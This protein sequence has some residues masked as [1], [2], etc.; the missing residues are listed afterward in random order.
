M[1]PQD[2]P[3]AL[4]VRAVG[5]RCCRSWGR[6][7]RRWFWKKSCWLLAGPGRNRLSPFLVSPLPEHH[8]EALLPLIV[9]GYSVSLGSLEWRDKLTINP[10]GRLMQWKEYRLRVKKP[11]S[12]LWPEPWAL[13]S[14]FVKSQRFLPAQRYRDSSHFSCVWEGITAF[15][16]GWGDEGPPLFS[17]WRWLWPV[18]AFAH[19]EGPLHIAGFAGSS[20]RRLAAPT[21]LHGETSRWA[22]DPGGQSDLVRSWAATCPA[23]QPGAQRSPGSCEE[24]PD[25]NRKS[26]VLGLGEATGAHPQLTLRGQRTFPLVIGGKGVCFEIQMDTVGTNRL[27]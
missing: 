8:L 24:A 13:V 6:A 5:A 23:G 12:A 9:L 4:W 17:S 11:S 21:A 20:W 7:Q 26:R 2:R 14:S 1:K 10:G 25:T 18:L 16:P 22:P 15:H 3:P 19:P 27:N